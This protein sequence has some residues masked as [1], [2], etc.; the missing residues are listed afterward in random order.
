M[1][2]LARLAFFSV[3]DNALS[4]SIPAE[5][6]S[7]VDLGFLDLRGNRLSGCVPAGL[8]A[9]EIVHFDRG[10]S[11]CAATVASV[12]DAIAFEDDD[13]VVFNVTV[14]VPEG[15]GTLS[16]SPGVALDYATVAGTAS[17]GSDYTSV[18]GTLTIPAGSRRATVAVPLRNNARAESTEAF[19]LRLSNPRG[20]VLA[21]TEAT[22]TIVDDD[23]GSPDPAAPLTVCDR[24]AVR[25]AVAGVFDV[26]QPGFD[27]SH[28]IFVD[29]DLT[30][31]GD[32]GSAVGYPTAVRVISGPD[33]SLG[34]SR[35]C[36]T[37][38][39][40]RQTTA[41]V[42]A[43]AGCRTFAPRLPAK[44]TQDGRST[45]ILQIPDTAVGQVQQLLVWVDLDR[46]GSHDRGEP[47]TYV[48]TD[49]VGRAGSD[50][51]TVEYALPADFEIEPLRGS[52]PVGRGG[53][54]TE[55]RLRLVARTGEAIQRRGSEPII[56]QAPVANA[57]VDAFVSIGPS[58]TAHV[59]CLVTPTATIPSPN[60]ANTCLTDPDGVFM[61]RYRVPT[62]AIRLTRQ[63]RDVV[64]VYID[65][66]RDG[67][68]DHNPNQPDHEPSATITVPIARAVNYIALGDSY[69]SGE[70]G[71]T[72]PTGAY[73]TGVSD[74]D[75][76]CRRWDQAYPYI[77]ANEVLG[78]SVLSID[79]TFATFACT[80][81][82]THNIHNPTDQDG[83]SLEHRETNRPSHRR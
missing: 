53:Q 36:I 73:Q 44:F 78:R 77:F 3:R 55:L 35:Y 56:Q 70:A 19:T 59:M 82:I 60:A 12:S 37:Q 57:P 68:H 23:S 67:T 33:A 80:G 43:A 1:G 71:D 83:D 54:D 40:T 14:A 21:A 4:G 61:V 72:P 46:D 62:S 16:T 22:A 6:G 2:G 76:E 28:H 5:I 27:R 69:S 7:L 42:A 63:Q 48:H 32:L 30:C 75:A 66:D 50:S 45:H 65:R 31:G 79:A 15:V 20:A 9:V 24:A 17:A 29:V 18:S 11:Y 38:T 58:H 41:S 13:A 47:Y 39:G 64:N 8:L 26:E 34:A 10:L 52:T 74:A 51:T 49:F 81:A 25:A